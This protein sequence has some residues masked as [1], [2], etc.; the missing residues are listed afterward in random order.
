MKLRGFWIYCPSQNLPIERSW[1][2]L[3]SMWFSWPNEGASLHINFFF[4]TRSN[5]LHNNAPMTLRSSRILPKKCLL[6]HNQFLLSWLQRYKKKDLPIRNCILLKEG[7]RDSWSA[8]PMDLQVLVTARRSSL[9]H[10][11]TK[12]YQ[13]YF[14]CQNYN[15]MLSIFFP[16][17]SSMAFSFR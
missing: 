3:V 15:S 5:T 13:P 1:S 4:I 8:F 9:C 12:S 6:S 11:E 2:N 14:A 10:P 16:S 7:I 17:T